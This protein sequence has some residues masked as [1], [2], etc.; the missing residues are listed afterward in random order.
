MAVGRKGGLLTLTTKGESG[1]EAQ[2]LANVVLA[3]LFVSVAPKGQDAIDLECLR[4]Q[5][6]DAQGN[7]A[8]CDGADDEEA[9]VFRD[10]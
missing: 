5:A 4:K 9:E 3:Q 10:G 8:S 7:E 2:T 6:G 1:E